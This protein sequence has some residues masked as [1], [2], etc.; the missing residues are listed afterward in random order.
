MDLS[1]LQNLTYTQDSPVNNDF[2]DQLTVATADGFGPNAAVVATIDDALVTPP[3]VGYNV[4]IHYDTDTGGNT[5]SS[6]FEF[7]GIAQATDRDA[8]AAQ[9]LA[10]FGGGPPVGPEFVRA[11]CNGDAN[12]NIADAIFL[13][14][15]LFPGPGGANEPPCDNACDANDDEGMNIADAIF[16]LSV[17]F[18]GPSGPPI[19]P[20]PVTCG[21]DPTAG[22]LSC[23]SFAPCP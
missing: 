5:V 22:T 17:L 2:T 8:V 12:T 16:I 4:M 3:A 19:L 1:G 23:D 20:A 6:S 18:P 21:I 11:N 10:G 13:L 15:T 14:G 7:G 9:I